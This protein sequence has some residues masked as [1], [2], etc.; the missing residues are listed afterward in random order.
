MGRDTGRNPARRPDPVLVAGGLDPRGIHRRPAGTIESPF[1]LATVELHEV[2]R[3][4]VKFEGRR[5][6]ASISWVLA[7]PSGLTV[8]PQLPGPLLAHHREAME[9]VRAKDAAAAAARWRLAAAAAQADDRCLVA[10][11][12]LS[13]A[14]KALADA[15]LWPKADW[16]Y[17]EAVTNVEQEPASEAAAQLL[18]ALRALGPSKRGKSAGLG[19]QALSQAGPPRAQ[20]PAS[21]RRDG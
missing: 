11:W 6:A 14:A 5:G 7:A 4:P 9:L 12:F 8:R 18:H 13:R 10:V 19:D 16:T 15:R 1:D 17:E 2:P 20:P 3:G 21:R